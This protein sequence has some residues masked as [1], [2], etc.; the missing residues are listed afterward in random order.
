M[1]LCIGM[2]V[3][4]FNVSERIYEMQMPPELTKKK[5]RLSGNILEIFDCGDQLCAKILF[6]PDYLEINID[7]LKDLH[8]GDQIEIDCTL[9]I[10][11]I[12]HCF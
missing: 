11:R 10:C 3:A 5:L 7:D 8:L 1:F 2:L 6:R 12:R 4:R 9:E